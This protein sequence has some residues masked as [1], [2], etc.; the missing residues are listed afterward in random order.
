M[1]RLLSTPLADYDVHS[2]HAVSRQLFSMPPYAAE[3]MFRVYALCRPPPAHTSTE[4][5]AQKVLQQSHVMLFVVQSIASD[6]QEAMSYGSSSA[7]RCRN[8]FFASEPAKE[9]GYELKASPRE[10]PRRR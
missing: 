10:L 6:V 3:W 2:A 9:Y 1:L 7:Q 8:R 4:L 5:Q